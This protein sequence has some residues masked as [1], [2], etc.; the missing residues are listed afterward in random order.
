MPTP[1][2]SGESEANFLQRCIPEVIKDKTAQDQKQ[3]AAICHSMFRKKHDKS[4]TK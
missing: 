2:R 4:K 1:P 3:A